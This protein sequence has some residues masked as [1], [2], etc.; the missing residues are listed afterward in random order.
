MKFGVFDHV[1]CSGTDLG[2]HLENRLKI[3][4]AY[5]RCGIHGYHVAEHH[6]T[7]LGLAPSPSV[8][9]SA[10]IQRTRRLKLG[11]LIYLLPLYHPL[12]LI[13]EVAMLDCMSAGRLMLGVGR[14]ASPIEVGFYGVSGKELQDRYAEALDI[15]LLGLQNETLNFEGKFHSFKDVPMTVRPHQKPYPELWY[16]AFS[17]E[18]TIWAARR[19]INIVTLAL[20]KEVKKITD[21]FRAEW[22]TAGGA[23]DQIPL[24]GVSRHIVIAET[25]AE[26]KEIAS[27]AYKRWRSSFAKLWIDGGISVPLSNLYPET[28]EELEAIRN[29]CAGSPQTVRRYALEEAERDGFNYLVSW[30]AFGDIAVRHAIRS[31]ELFSQHVMP[32]FDVEPTGQHQPN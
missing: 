9:L 14:G 7:P 6:G 5:D 1:D 26:A 11:P 22:A 23:A 8:F 20:D 15:L 10:V 27:S 2:T 16:G 17:A 18:S 28:W 3:A 32:A 29:G 12:R 25:D 21:L 31:V 4:E 30:F 13:E 24:M 19:G